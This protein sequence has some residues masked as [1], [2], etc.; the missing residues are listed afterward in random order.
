MR[1]SITAIAALAFAAAPVAT[2]AAAPGGFDS[3]ADYV[4]QSGGEFD[5]NPYDYDILLNAVIAAELVDP[6]SDPDAELTLFAP[7]DR[8]MIRLARDLGYDGRDEEGAWNF[9]VA[10]LT[11]LGGGDPIP[12]LTDILLYHVAP[13]SLSAFDVFLLGWFRQPIVT[14]QGGEIRPRVFRLRD[15]EPDLRDP[16][17]FWPLNIRAGAGFVHTL[18]RVLIPIDIP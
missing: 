1:K 8:G 10:A 9:L 5:S 2:T 13:E 6:L 3:I 12:L 11:D 14:L 4:S 17:L 15:N 16:R 18:N 7:N